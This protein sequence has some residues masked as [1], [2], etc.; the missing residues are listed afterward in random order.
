MLDIHKNKF[1]IFVETIGNREI[2]RVALKSSTEPVRCPWHWET[3]DGNCQTNFHKNWEI[4][5]RFKQIYR[6][7]NHLESHK[8]RLFVSSLLMINWEQKES[9]VRYQ[10]GGW[11]ARASRRGWQILWALYFF[12]ILILS[13]LSIFFFSFSLAPKYGRGAKSVN[14]IK[15]YELQLQYVN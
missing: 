3:S 1:I 14:R 6:T 5:S 4:T 2:Y 7:L 9:D 15:M 8:L 13:L 12:I 11:R 10:S